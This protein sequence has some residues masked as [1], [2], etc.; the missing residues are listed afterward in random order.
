MGAG[1]TVH[2]AYAYVPFKVPFV[3]VRV[4]DVQVCPDGTEDA[5]YAVRLL[6]EVR[7]SIFEARLA[8]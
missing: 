2:D 8:I 5:K 7:T 4:C 6:D 1:A 3:Q